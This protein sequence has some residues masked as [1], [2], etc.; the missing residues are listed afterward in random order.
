MPIQ[1]TVISHRLPML[2][3][4]L[5]LG[6]ASAPMPYKAPMSVQPASGGRID[7][8]KAVV[9]VDSSGSIEEQFVDTKALFES[10]VAGMPNGSYKAGSIVFGG[11]ER[12]VTALAGFDR[13]RLAAAAKRSTHLEGTT[14]IASVLSEVGATLG[15]TGAAALV[16]ISDGIATDPWGQDEG[17]PASAIAT[18]EGLLEARKGKTCVHA[19]Q[20]GADPAGSAALAAITAASGCGSVVDGDGMN[21]ASLGAFERAVF[22]GAPAPPP[23]VAPAEPAP[24]DDDS[25]GVSDN[26]DRCPNTPRGARVDARGCWTLEGVKFATNSADLVGESRA[27]LADAVNVLRQNPSLRIRIDGHTDSQGAAAYNLDLSK[28]RAAAVRA[29]LIEAGIAATRLESQGFG[30]EQPAASN[31]D[32]AGRA[33]NRRTELTVID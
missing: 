5:A 18:V 31:D 24:G 8:D 21:A 9:V 19:I 20:V 27:T 13:A 14:P 33:A 32:A 7:V 4:A 28:R 22:F 23:P 3:I 30:E 16:L 25:D 29:H 15:D 6:C 12:D 10:F 1:R 11:S 2:F 26:A 17:D